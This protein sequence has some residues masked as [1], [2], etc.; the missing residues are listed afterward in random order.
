MRQVVANPQIQGQIIDYAKQ[1]C[2]VF[3]SFQD[4]CVAD[5]DQYAPMAFGMILAYLQPEQVSTQQRVLIPQHVYGG[6]VP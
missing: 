5:V 4:T 6:G 3:P 1:A 2:S